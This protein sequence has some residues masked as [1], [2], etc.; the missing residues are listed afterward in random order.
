VNDQSHPGT[1]RFIE[2]ASS[3]LKNARRP[4][5][6]DRLTYANGR[7]PAAMLAAGE[8]H[9]DQ[10]LVE[11]G[12]ETLSWLVDVETRGDHFSF[13]AVGGRGWGDPRPAGF[14]QQPVEAAAMSDACE[15]AW[16]ATG[17]EHW[18]EAT[19]RC[20]A[21]LLGS[22]DSSAAL[23]NPVTGATMDGLMSDG[24][25][26]NSGAESTIAGLAVLQACQRVS[27]DMS[28]TAATSEAKASR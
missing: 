15:R 21:W 26:E 23:Y 16:R 27:S 18:R 24:V 14:D 1:E 10:D 22:N 11:M 4:W 17:D 2:A 8:V 20:G 9:G 5:P 28:P 3:V 19:L 6:E 13:T 12:I 25:N 7:I